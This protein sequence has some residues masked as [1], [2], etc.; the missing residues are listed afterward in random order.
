VAETDA[1]VLEAYRRVAQRLRTVTTARLTA[2]WQ[3]LPD[4]TDATVQPWAARG[5]MQLD[6]AQAAV[7]SATAAYIAATAPPGDRMAVPTPPALTASVALRGVPADE[8][9][10]RAPEQARYGLSEGE[11]PAEAGD[12]GTLRLIAI[13]AVGLQLAHTHAARHSMTKR[14][15]TRY[16]RATRAGACDLCSLSV[17]QTYYSSNLMPIHH[18]CACVVVP[19][20]IGGDFNDT[21]SL[22]DETYHDEVAVHEHDEIGPVLTPEGDAFA[23]PH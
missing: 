18:H 13:V 10:L 16:H 17:S 8:L 5:G 19:D 22:A 6:A 7:G 14:H 20:W 11:A 4:W 9:L 12:R 21:G 15:V 23:P 3:S 2:T 1:A